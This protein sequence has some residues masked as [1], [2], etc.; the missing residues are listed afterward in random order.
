M[1]LP[2]IKRKKKWKKIKELG[3]HMRTLNK[4]CKGKEDW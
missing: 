3:E 4:R 2:K 1:E